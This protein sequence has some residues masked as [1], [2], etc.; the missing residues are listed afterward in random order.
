MSK[1]IC[2]DNGHEY[3]NNDLQSWCL[4][5]GIEIQMTAPYTPEQNGVAERWNR[6]V[7]ELA[8][9]MI[10][11]CKDVPK[12]SWPEAMHCVTYIRNCA[13][14]KAIP[15]Q[16]PYEKWSGNHPD[17]SFIQE[18]GWPVW[19]L[20]QELNPSKLDAKARRFTFIGYEEGPNAIQYYNAVK[21]T[22]KVSHEY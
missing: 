17:V 11:A 3:V 1:A 10:F 9:M 18:F 20:N 22:V 4:D 12:E 21:K 5:H 6:T 2:A 16:T 8:C 19:I 13:Y 15:D 14:T 7:I